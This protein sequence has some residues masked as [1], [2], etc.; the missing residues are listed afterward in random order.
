[1][2]A[3]FF[4]FYLIFKNYKKIKYQNNCR[5]RIEILN[6]R[7]QR[8]IKMLDFTEIKNKIS[9]KK[10]KVKNMFEIKPRYIKSTLIRY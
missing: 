5:D 10:I 2:S 4:S 9:L 7:S 1:M 8:K 3:C 6:Y